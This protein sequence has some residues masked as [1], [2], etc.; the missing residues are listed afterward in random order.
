MNRMW[1]MYVE[2]VIERVILFIFRSN[3]PVVLQSKVY[4]PNTVMH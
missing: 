2:F 3:I 4:I 1:L